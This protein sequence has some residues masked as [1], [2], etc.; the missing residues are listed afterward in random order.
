MVD[1]F[2]IKEEKNP[3]NSFSLKCRW[4]WSYACDFYCLV[5]PNN[6][7]IIFRLPLLKMDNSAPV[8]KST[9]I[10]LSGLEIEQF[11]LMYLKPLVSRGFCMFITWST[12]N[13][14][15]G[16]W[17]SKSFVALG[18]VCDFCFVRKKRLVWHFVARYF[19]LGYYFYQ[20]WR[21]MILGYDPFY[22]ILDIVY[23]P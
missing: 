21:N 13:T 16:L 23:H 7:V 12:E 15:F 14:H 9:V 4:L 1:Y 2:P 19:H 20:V 18:L 17:T 8:S 11:N 3:T 22:G 6:G 10:N 5:R